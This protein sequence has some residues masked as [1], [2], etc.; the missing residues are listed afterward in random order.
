MNIGSETE[1][2]PHTDNSFYTS[3]EFSSIASESITEY[4]SGKVED[5]DILEK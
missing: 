5:M 2:V 3:Q 1:Y 4:R